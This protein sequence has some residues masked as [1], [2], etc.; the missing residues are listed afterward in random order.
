MPWPESQRR[1]CRSTLRCYHSSS[2]SACPFF[3]CLRLFPVVLLWLGRP[4]LS[5]AHTISVFAALQCHKTRTHA[6]ESSYFISKLWPFCSLHIAPVHCVRGPAIHAS[7]HYTHHVCTYLQ[8]SYLQ[9]YTN[10]IHSCTN[11]EYYFHTFLSQTSTFLHR[12]R[13]YSI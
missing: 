2:F 5:R 13:L 9:S 1:I 10:C 12:G 6:R 7:T 3:D 4:I 11:L 8:T